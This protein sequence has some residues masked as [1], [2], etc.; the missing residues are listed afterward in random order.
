MQILLTKKQGRAMAWHSI[1]GSRIEHGRGDFKQPLKWLFYSL[2]KF[3]VNCCCLIWKCLYSSVQGSLGG[4]SSLGFIE[5]LTSEV[6]FLSFQQSQRSNK[7]KL[8]F[9]SGIF[10]PRSNK[11][12]NKK[13]ERKRNKLVVVTMAAECNS[14]CCHIGA[15]SSGRTNLKEC[16]QYCTV[17]ES[18]LGT[19]EW[20]YCHGNA[21]D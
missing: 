6:V 16:I 21:G 4:I 7:P 9:Q 17:T 1:A 13:K 5:C 20:F 19:E 15:E 2:K 3:F 18:R 12:K 10:S 11:K 14:C 8:Q